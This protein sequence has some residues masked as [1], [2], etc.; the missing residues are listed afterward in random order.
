M[1]TFSGQFGESQPGAV[2][3]APDPGSPGAARIAWVIALVLRAVVVVFNQLG[4]SEAPAKK[5]EAAAAVEPPDPADPFALTA[6]LF[7]KLAGDWLKDPALRQ[8]V[9]AN[10]TESARSEED[11]VRLAIVAADLNGGKAGV[12]RLDAAG[13]LKGALAEDAATLRELYESGAID[14]SAKR[15]QLIDHHAWFGKL[16]LAYGKADT[17][18]QRAPLLEGGGKLIGVG[19]LG[20][21][22]AFIAFIGGIAACITMAVMMG[23]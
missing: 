5:P 17:D 9:V 18:P 7:V 16:A 20:F 1:S 4:A 21:T 2:V 12:E 23:S 8:P 13:E 6:K 19:A 11:K 22:L 10:L 3:D 15:Q 14:D